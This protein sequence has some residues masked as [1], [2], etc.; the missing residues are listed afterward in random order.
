VTPVSVLVVGAGNAYRRDD[1]AGVAA[2]ERLGTLP[3]HV[4]VSVTTGDPASLLDQWEDVDVVVVIDATISGAAPGTIRR[5]DAH[6]APLPAVFS[7]S[8]THAIGIGEAIE[9]ARTLG[10]LPARLIVFAIEGRD[11]GTGEGLSAEV[12]AAVDQVVALVA[13]IAEGTRQ[14][15]HE[16]RTGWR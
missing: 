10:R 11:F 5:Y 8:S 2:V 4:R 3:D 6:A 1:G 14:G 12:D 7:R 16:S 15:H 13:T 9:L